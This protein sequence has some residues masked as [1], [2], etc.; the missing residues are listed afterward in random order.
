L[1]RLLKGGYNQKT[2]SGAQHRQSCRPCA[3]FLSPFVSYVVKQKS[4]LS[5]LSGQPRQPLPR[6]K[7]KSVLS[8][9]SGQP[10]QPLP[11]A[12][13]KSALSAISGQPHQPLPL[14]KN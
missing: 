13:L 7:L 14:W 2:H 12:K 3:H 6:A 5:A 1:H 10:R 9:L 4:A 8:A 11:R